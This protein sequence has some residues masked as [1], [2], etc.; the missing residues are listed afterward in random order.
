MN[1]FKSS[2][3]FCGAFVVFVLLS[4]CSQAQ[5]NVDSMILSWEKNGIPK[6]SEK[7]YQE[8]KNSRA[9]VAAAKSAKA[10]SVGGEKT[11]VLDPCGNPGLELGNFTQWGRY[12][13]NAASSGTIIPVTAYGSPDYSSYGNISFNSG[14]QSGSLF[15]LHS[16]G[17]LNASTGM[18]Y[19]HF[20][21][22]NGIYN[23]PHVDPVN[24][25]NYSA[26]IN[27]A[28]GG[29]KAVKLEYYFTASANNPTFDLNYAVFMSDGGHSQGHQAAFTYR[30]EDYSTGQILPLPNAS[31]TE[32]ATSV[33]T[34]PTFQ[35]S[36]YNDGGDD[37]YYK[38]WTHVSFNL[39]QHVGKN[40]RLVVE[41][42]DCIYGAHF[43]YAY[44]DLSCSTGTA[45]VQNGSCQNSTAFNLQAT[46]GLLSYQWLDPAGNTISAAQTGTQSTLDL[47]QYI[48][49]CP[50]SNCSV[51]DGDV[52]IVQVVTPAGCTLNLPVTMQIEE[53]VITSSTITP[54]CK[55]NPNGAIAVTASGGNGAGTYT[56]EW[57]DATCSG[58]VLGNSSSLASLQ[59]G[60]YCIHI[61]SGTCPPADSL[62]TIPYIP[63]DVSSQTVDVYC[64]DSSYVLT[65]NASGSN[66]SWYQNGQPAPGAQ[67]N[68]YAADENNY[69]IPYAVT[70]INSTDGCKDSVN[71]YLN[72]AG[73][74][75]GFVA[76]YCPN[77]SLALVYFP[78][79]SSNNA[80]QWYNGTIPVSGG[81]GGTNDTLGWVAVSNVN[82]YHVTFNDGACKQLA[83][84][85][86][87]LFPDDIFIPDT[88]TNIFTP[89]NDSVNDLFFPFKSTG[90]DLKEIHKETSDFE[91]LVFNRWGNLIFRST[92][93]GVQWNGNSQGGEMEA[94][95]TYFW[96]A[97]FYSN[98]SESNAGVIKKGF[99]LLIR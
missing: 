65:T 24:G 5:F 19:D 79:A 69:S 13:G 93:Y 99:V 53:V 52:F 77:D 34:D 18:G 32:N 26:R 43:C 16:A 33:Q 10:T 89:N 76:E 4:F 39:C 9:K 38:G 72:F 28:N 78:S 46:P 88:T 96:I 49:N 91:F 37:V 2:F 60:S 66:Y 41:A 70:Y 98:C 14:Y 54:T 44:V 73:D 35:E 1:Y 82:N 6:G 63:M 85:P 30:L 64:L 27:N 81:N 42:I 8:Y 51:N 80:F 62:F 25:G 57:H 15:V 74:F 47:N 86:T 61:E 29:E 11:T 7:D 83:T 20:S 31:Y 67:T 71:F 58:A 90:Y 97:K 48:A 68:S 12:Y 84:H 92:V 22:D 36:W 87:Q 59:G 95:G 17:S 75:T 21:Y 45:I 23:V 50:G 56:Y 55:E 40:L 3:L 94:D